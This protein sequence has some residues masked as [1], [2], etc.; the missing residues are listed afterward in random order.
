[1][2]LFVKDYEKICIFHI[3]NIFAH[4]RNATNHRFFS[5]F[6][7]LWDLLCAKYEINRDSYCSQR[8]LRVP[9]GDDILAWWE[10]VAPRHLG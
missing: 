2:L 1:M 10:R 4:G 7:F 3:F 5:I 6:H 8:S 9:C